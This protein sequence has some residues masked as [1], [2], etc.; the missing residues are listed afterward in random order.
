MDKSVHCSLVQL[1]SLQDFLTQ[2]FLSSRFF[3]LPT[4]FSSL[5]SPALIAPSLCTIIIFSKPKTKI[6]VG[7]EGYG[8]NVVLSLS[9]VWLFAILW[10]VASLTLLVWIS[11]Q[12]YWIGLP[13]PPPG[14]LPHPGI[15]PE[16][17]PVAGRRGTREG[18]TWDLG[19]K[20]HD[21]KLLKFS[22]SQTL[23]FYFLPLALSPVPL[24]PFSSPSSLFREGVWVNEERTRLIMKSLSLW[25]FSSLV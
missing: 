6:L 18:L 25:W 16:S 1:S 7:F 5:H 8:I 10:T 23:L 12:E 11:R 15:E 20:F 17:P 19:G 14:D 24:L 21:L 13:F 2:S 3:F 22:E 4:Y 9:K